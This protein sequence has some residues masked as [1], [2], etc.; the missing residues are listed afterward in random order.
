VHTLAVVA[1]IFCRLQSVN[2][3]I[4]LLSVNAAQWDLGIPINIGIKCTQA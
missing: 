1:T 4:Y 2:T 3:A